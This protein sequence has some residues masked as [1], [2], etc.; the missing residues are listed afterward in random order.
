MRAI[1]KEMK[2]IAESLSVEKT[3]SDRITQTRKY[4]LITPLFGGGVRPREND[5]SKL[6]RETSVRG[7]LR[8]WWRAMRGTGSIAEMKK[9]EDAIFGS[10]GENA[11]QSKVLVVVNVNNRGASEKIFDTGGKNPKPLDKWKQVAYAAFALQPTNEDPQQKEIRVGVEFTLEISFPQN[12]KDDIEA[13]LWAWETFGGIGGRT[14][15]GFGALELLEATENGK[16]IDIRKYNTATVEQQIKDDLQK[17]LSPN[18]NA[19]TNQF[20]RLSATV[21]FKTKAAAN[22]TEA[23][24]YAIE[25]L[26]NFRQVR[27]IDP[28]TKRPHRNKWSEPD[29]LRRIFL[30]H[31]RGAR[32]KHE[33]IRNINKF[34]RAE[35]GLPIVFH[36]QRDEGIEKDFTLQGAKS[37]KIERLASPLI[38]RPLKCDD[39]VVSLA[40]I[41]NAPRAPKG[42]LEVYFGKEFSERVNSD[43]LEKS[44]AD[45]L[46]RNGLGKQLAGKTDVLQAFL[47]FF[48]ADEVNNQARKN[49]PDNRRRNYK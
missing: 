48:A 1:S 43:R 28:Q 24:K 16:S 7:Q 10:G 25:K 27:D 12:L 5:T 35:F 30:K 6:I 37:E 26:K 13:A 23:W 36:F 39:R 32:L 15:R 41:L 20:P 14:R 4:K 31:K 3:E 42:G 22:A 46:T 17:H 40:L 34:P 47:D 38:L 2:Q 8:F 45:E 33:P 11:Q 21:S 18:K 19:D 44:E 29:E 49:Y 9:R